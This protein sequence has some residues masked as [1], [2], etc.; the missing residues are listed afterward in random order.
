MFFQWHTYQ[1]NIILAREVHLRL[2]S[3]QQ[4]SQANLILY[5]TDRTNKSLY[6]QHALLLAPA[7]SSKSSWC[8]C[9]ADKCSQCTHCAIKHLQAMRRRAPQSDLLMFRA[10][11]RQ[12]SLGKF[13]WN[14]VSRTMISLE[15]LPR[16]K[17]MQWLMWHIPL[18]MIIIWSLNLS[19]LC[20]YHVFT[21]IWCY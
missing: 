12:N 15:I 13:N 19:L 7:R 4:A 2:I 16:L 3:Y 18:D 11:F 17:E 21:A 5:R 20:V 6:T 1:D 9:G 8:I 14:S 10:L